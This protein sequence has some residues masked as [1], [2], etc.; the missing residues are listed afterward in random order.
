M[1][2]M[3]LP[4]TE[5]NL[6]LYVRRSHLQT[7]LWKAA[8]QQGPPNV[9][10]TKFGWEVTEG[11]PSLC[12]AT[13]LHAPQCLIDV[14]NCGFKAERTARSTENCSCHKNNMSCTVYCVCSSVDGCCTPF[15][16]REE[17]IINKQHMNLKRN[18]VHNS[19]I[20]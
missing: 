16:M 19:S 12:I 11:I 2:M 7:M 17:M 8:D 9:D 13:G 4:P 18:Y 3:T 1:R 15:T 20:F 10:I 6:C 14:I 5:T